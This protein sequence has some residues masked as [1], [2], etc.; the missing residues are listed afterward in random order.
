MPTNEKS[1]EQKINQQLWEHQ[2][3][4]IRHVE[5]DKEFAIYRA[6]IS[7][8]PKKVELSMKK[9]KAATFD[10]NGGEQ[11]GVLSKDPLQN[12]KYNVVIFISLTTR[13][14]TRYGLNREVAY[15][16]SDVLIR[17]LDNC[18]SIE[19]TEKIHEKAIHIFTKHMQNKR[20]N[21]V[22][23]MQV[24]RCLEYIQNNLQRD[25]KLATIAEHFHLNPSYLSRLFKQE[26]NQS[27]S[28]YIKQQRLVSACNML[29]LSDYSIS[30]ISE[31][32]HFSSQSHFTSSF[33]AQYG[34][35]PKKYRDLRAR[36]DWHND[37]TDI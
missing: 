35:T 4:G 22:Y 6:I 28:A 31:L 10:E 14:C 9:Y 34:V 36:A 7:G 5:Y 16:I 33:Q 12:A 24:S 18:Y 19:D 29:E 8:D 26:M 21:S 27:I 20:K 1:I 32:L 25:L 2:F 37:V 11:N 30:Q 23:S 3:A 15:S 17:E 13:Y